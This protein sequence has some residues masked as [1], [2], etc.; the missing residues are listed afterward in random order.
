MKKLGKK[1]GQRLL[2]FSSQRIFF[3]T[4]I[5]LFPLEIRGREHLETERPVILAGNHSGLLDT[6]ILVSLLG[7]RVFFFMHDSVHCWPVIGRLVRWAQIIVLKPGNEIASIRK[8]IQT[9]KKGYSLCI[10]P[11]GKLTQ[12]GELQPFRPGIAIIHQKAQVPI[13]PFYIHGSFECWSWHKRLAPQ[14]GKV[15]IEFGKPLMLASCR[16]QAVQQLETSVNTLKRKV[17]HSIE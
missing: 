13:L 16:K 15:I 12:D 5:F 9:L 11:E 1:L 14:P 3:L 6:P 17:L 7:Q 8:S 4:F 10:F 2:Y